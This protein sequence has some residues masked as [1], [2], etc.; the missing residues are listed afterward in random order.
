MKRPDFRIILGALFIL[1]G[2]LLLLEKFGLIRGA[3]DLFW[4][5]VLGAAGLVFLYTFITDRTHWWAAFPAFTLLGLAAS[6]LLPES[7]EVW[8]GLAFLGGIS[9]GFWAVYITHREHWWAIIPGGVLLTLGLTSVLAD[10]YG[11][12]ESGGI[13]FIGLG[14]TFLLVAL[15]ARMNWAYIPT[16][17]LIVF[18]VVIGT[19]FA[20]YT[21]YIWI[22]ALFLGGAF[23]IWQYF[24]SR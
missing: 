19:P 23:L 1:G 20:G 8:A 3:S 15:L 13:F 11:V 17:V 24:R 12:L 2:G 7:L 18:G 16:L 5:G 6:S 21:D 10:V 9:L 4:G 14:L 22:A